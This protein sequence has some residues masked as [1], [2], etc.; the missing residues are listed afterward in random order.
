MVDSHLWNSPSW[1]DPVW[2]TVNCEIHRPEVTL[3]LTVNCGIHRPEVTLWLTVNYGIHR[4]E[5]TLC[6]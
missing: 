6:G 2:L 3:W 1:G 5:V 4:P